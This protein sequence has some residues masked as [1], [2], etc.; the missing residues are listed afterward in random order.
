MSLSVWQD[1]EK[2]IVNYV[3]SNWTSTE[4]Q[5]PNTVKDMASVEFYISLKINPT[6]Q[7]RLTIT[8]N[9]D[10]GIMYKGEVIFT[11]SRSINKG[12]GL[13]KQYVDDINDLFRYHT[14]TLGDASIIQFY[15]PQLLQ[16]G[17]VND[18]WEELITISFEYLK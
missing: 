10:T 4:I 9:A 2:A 17:K 8:G 18:R 12:T 15:V 1:I 14:L 11:F 13:L 3:G 16:I 5:Y 6:T 7:Q